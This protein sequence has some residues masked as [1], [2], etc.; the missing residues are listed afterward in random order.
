MLVSSTLCPSDRSSVHLFV[1]HYDE[2]RVLVPVDP[3]AKY[4][5]LQNYVAREWNLERESIAFETDELN[6]CAGKRIRIHE[7]A[8]IVVKDIVG[9]VYVRIRYPSHRRAKSEGRQEILAP[10]VKCEQKREVLEMTREPSESADE[11]EVEQQTRTEIPQSEYIDVAPTDGNHGQD[12]EINNHEH[13]PAIAATRSPRKP[14]PLGDTLNLFNDEADAEEE[15]EEPLKEKEPSTKPGLAKEPSSGRR[16]TWR[17]LLSS[18]RAAAEKPPNSAT[19][20]TTIESTLSTYTPRSAGESQAK[21]QLHH[22]HSPERAGSG[23]PERVLIIVEPPPDSIYET[24]GF[25]IRREHSVRT[26]L[27]G[28]SKA[29]KIDHTKARLR[30]V[31]DEDDQGK[32]VTVKCHDNETMTSLKVEESQRFVITMIHEEEEE[33]EE[34]EA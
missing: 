24:R 10:A 34:S 11:A 22:E 14:K 18:G 23:D 6:I 8:W 3:Y 27:K 33:E 28:A 13:D 2:D 15:G 25:R 19:T 17:Q 26:V 12:A 29:F 30:M 16:L 32:L 20:A 9:N 21:S 5:D 4:A 7:E 1:V 31:V